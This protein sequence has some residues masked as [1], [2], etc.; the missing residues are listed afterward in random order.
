M[1]VVAFVMSSAACMAIGY[2]LGGMLGYNQGYRAG[3]RFTEQEASIQYKLA[4]E[5][6]RLKEHNTSKGNTK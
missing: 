1:I 3:C 5:T 6:Q 2:A 4:H